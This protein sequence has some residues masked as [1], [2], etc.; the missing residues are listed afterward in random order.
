ML[1][2]S[3]GAGPPKWELHSCI[4]VYLGK[5]LFHAGSVTLVWNPT[6]V[7]IST[8]FQVVFD[9]EFSTVYYMKVGTIPP[10][11]ENIVKYS[12]EMATAQDV[13]LED[14]WLRGQYNKYGSDVL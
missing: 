1:Q 10:N 14:T 7:L 5:S 6:T 13:D 8:K 11:W 3:E 12:S 4:G 2:N 9:D